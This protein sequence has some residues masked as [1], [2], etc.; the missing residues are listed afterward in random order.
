[1]HIFILA[2]GIFL[3]SSCGQDR[4]NSQIKSIIGQDNRKQVNDSAIKSL[5]G[6]ITSPF[7]TC[8]AYISGKTELTTA[9]HCVDMAHT[10]QVMFTTD[11]NINIPILSEK[12]YFEQADVIKLIIPE[13]ENF[14]SLGKFQSDLP[15]TVLGYDTGKE[16]V[17]TDKCIFTEKE[18][19]MFPGVIFHGCDTIK[20]ASGAPLLQNGKV[21]GIHIGTVVDHTINVAVDFSQLSTVNLFDLVY[22]PER[23]CDGHLR[24]YKIFKNEESHW[25][26]ASLVAM[27][28][29]SWL[30]PLGGALGAGPAAVAM[31]RR[32]KA[33]REM[34]AYKICLKDEKRKAEELRRKQ[35]DNKNK[36]KDINI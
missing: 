27:A 19:N 32:K 22:E 33:D 4:K 29:G 16:R 17:L 28:G 2:L 8:T 36:L 11:D 9:L 3:I 6:K 15:L 20:G 10:S 23:S 34:R 18:K 26:A 12:K 31:D 35:S 7:G 14:I 13:Q 5:V 24:R 25:A 21:V 30:G 1:M